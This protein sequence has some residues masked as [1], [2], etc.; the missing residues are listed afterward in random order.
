VVRMAGVEGWDRYLQV[1]ESLFEA[2]HDGC[3]C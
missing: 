2:G 3:V 1:E